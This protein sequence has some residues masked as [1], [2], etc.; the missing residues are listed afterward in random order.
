MNVMLEIRNQYHSLSRTNKKIADFLLADTERFLNSTALQ[1]AEA[2]ST[3]PASIIRFVRAFGYSGLEEFKIYLAKS[4][5]KEDEIGYEMDT[6]ISKNDDID[7]MC[8]KMS[9]LLN[10]MA[11]DFFYQLDKESFIEAVKILQKARHIHILGIG[12]SMLPAYD[13]YHKLRRADRSAYYEFDSHMGVEFF[14]YINEQDAVLAFSYSGQSSEIIY[15][16]EIAKE[17]GAKVIAVSRK[18]E[19]PLS[20]LA[21]VWLSIPAN[22]Q[23]TRVMAMTSKYATMMMGDLLYLS[24][25][26]K[27]FDYIEKELVKTSVLTR[28]MKRTKD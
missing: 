6:I 4:I 13:L 25:I 11:R 9:N 17:K 20:A 26:Q 27:D 12:S 1:I 28:K 24:I 22:E 15:P 8:N 3:S 19:S 14:N 18:V 7:T 16:C 23:L 10:N 5:S 21:D 2:S